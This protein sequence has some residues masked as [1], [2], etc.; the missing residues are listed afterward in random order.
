MNTSSRLLLPLLLIFTLITAASAKPFEQQ[1]K[2]IRPV[3]PTKV[4]GKIEVLEIF[5]YG[6]P[7]CYS[8]EPYVKKWLEEKPDDVEF[9][10]MPAIFNKS[11]IPHAKAYFTAIK[12]GVLEKIHGPLFKALHKDKKK[13][14]DEKQLGK[15]F[16][17]QG[18]NGDDFTRIFNSNEVETQVK[19]SFVMGQRYGIT[20]VPAVIING[21][22][23]TSGS[24]AGTYDDVL[25]VI[26]KLV[27]R[28]RERLKEE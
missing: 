14:F 4:E 20:G 7:H 23:L 25:K 27:D 15:F 16:T 6:C 11:W 26:N 22:F 28:E 5:W 19:E 1:F 3:Q 8:F 24:H 18:V 9:R 17:N 10:R 13:I 21:K 2:N 12:L